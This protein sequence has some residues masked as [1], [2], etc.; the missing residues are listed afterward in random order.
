M[1]NDFFLPR[2]GLLA[3]AAGLA[4]TATLPV[5]A[6]AAA[7]A[8]GGHFR[9]G[10]AD[11]ATSDGLDPAVVDTQFQVNLE[12]QLRNN[13]VEVGPSGQIVPELAESWE[14]SP[15]AKTWTFKIR[16]G[17]QFHTGKTMTARDVV[18]S[19]NLHTAPAS[20][21]PAK[22]FVKQIASLKTDGDNV[23]VFELK[24]GNV[25]FPA[26]TAYGAFYIVPEGTTDFG[27][28]VGTGGY[29]LEQLQP[30]VKSIVKRNPNYWKEGRAHFD[31]IE[32]I[33][34]KDAT[35]RANALL[36][37]QIDAYNAVDPKTVKLLKRNRSI[38]INRVTSKAH[39]DFAMMVNSNQFKDNDI[40]LAMKY[41]IDRED[42]VKRVLNGF[43]SVGNDNP[44]SP[45][46]PEYAALPQ[47]TY[48]PDKTK[49]HLNKA[50]VTGL[51]VQLF[52][53]ETPFAG[54]TDAAL[55]YREHA[56]KAGI[57]IDVVKTPEDGYWDNI[58]TKKPLCAERWS[59]RVNADVMFSLAYTAEG[60]KAGWNATAMDDPRV[61]K[62]VADARR[63]FDEAKRRAMYAE[64]QQI[65]QDDGGAIIFAFA[66]FLDATGRTVQ[67]GPLSGEWALDG[68]RAAE[69]WWFA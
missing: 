62:L 61:N 22:P 15:D 54:A 12:W 25:G 14:G 45:V 42:M 34:M 29:I 68:G 55:L 30:G 48:D 21:S 27:K 32:M 65:I 43:G 60:I 1:T 58:W 20:R 39:Y 37:G 47:R 19:F 31:S 6:K 18:Y 9:V 56:A 57:G 49:F 69:R 4:A 53:S 66:D 44:L 26:I 63:E 10:I 28:G 17:V 46:Y 2:R 7:P 3:G 59:G 41:A 23:V 24:D 5:R 64:V 13:L 51:K 40:R 50:G 16:K 33:C 52:V 35:A 36:T 8:K 67:H 11:F 38:R